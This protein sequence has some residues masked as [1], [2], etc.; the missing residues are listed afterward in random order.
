MTTVELI[1]EA[2]K[3][4][5]SEFAKRTINETTEI[6][7]MADATMGTIDVGMAIICD[8]E[9]YIYNVALY[10]KDE[11]FIEAYHIIT[12]WYGNIMSSEEIGEKLY[13]TLAQSVMFGMEE[14]VKI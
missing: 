4:E 6:L 12:D 14:G 9:G 7:C 1:M 11:K 8:G 2:A 13:D 3:I 10:D 5:R